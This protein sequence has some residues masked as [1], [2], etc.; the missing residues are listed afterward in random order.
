MNNIYIKLARDSIKYYFSNQKYLPVP[1]D[2]SND[3]KK[4]K[5]GC[6]VS[7]HLKNQPKGKNPAFIKTSAGKLRGCIGTIS[8]T[9]KNLGL[10]IIKNAVS[11]ATRDPRFE[12]LKKDELKDIKISI[13]VL[14]KPEPIDNIAKLNPKK[15]GIIIKHADG[16]TGLLLPNI[17]GVDSVEKQI[18]IAKQK[19]GILSHESIFIFRF[20][21]KRYEE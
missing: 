6:F 3:L 5:S 2:I 20:K 16:R 11:A 1:D 7:L 8:A 17:E 9:Q 4:Q 13:D 10:E 14:E 12:P 21:V 19:A 15:Y 18:A